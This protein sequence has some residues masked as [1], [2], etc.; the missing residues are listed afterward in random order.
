VRPSS[1][2]LQTNAFGN[3]GNVA[4]DAASKGIAVGK[5]DGDNFLDLVVS[6]SMGLVLYRQNAAQRGRS[7]CTA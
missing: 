2:R 5:F 1:S 6:T 3:L 4:F 7:R